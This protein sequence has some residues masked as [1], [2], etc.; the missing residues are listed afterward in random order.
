MMRE[1]KDSVRQS[2]AWNCLKLQDIPVQLLMFHD[3]SAN[4]T[5]SILFKLIYYLL[6]VDIV[7]IS[8]IMLHIAI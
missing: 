7:T 5:S 2:T 4:I 1:V 6:D 3:F 8:H